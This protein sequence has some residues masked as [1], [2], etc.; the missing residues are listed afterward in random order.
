M[1]VTTGCQRCLVTPG[2]TAS[3]GNITKALQEQTKAWSNE[4]HENPG[5]N[6]PFLGLNEQ[7]FAK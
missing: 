6:D 4:L 1:C 7:W 2:N 5:V 3:T